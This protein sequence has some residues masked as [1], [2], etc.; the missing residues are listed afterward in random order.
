MLPVMSSW[1]DLDCW[2]LDALAATWRGARP[3]PHVVLDGAIFPGRLSELR[4]AF[5]EEPA[6]LIHD[7]IYEVNASAPALEHPVLQALR[8]ELG[9][10]RA[11]AAVEKITGKRAGRVEMRGYAFEE[12]H[13]LLP[14]SDHRDDVGRLIA[15]AYYL[16]PPGPLEGGELELYECAFD[17]AEIVSTVPSVRIAPTPNRLVLFDVGDASLH[18]VREVTRGVR[19]SLSGWFY[20]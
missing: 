8:D 14:H 15:F 4:D 13:Y 6:S 12:G 17:G 1:L 18:E 5:V 9:G 20:S 19:F 10:E 2:D 3:F 7:E 11:R 16:E